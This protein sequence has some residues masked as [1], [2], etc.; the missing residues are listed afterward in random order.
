MS[1]TRA[2]TER[3]QFIELDAKGIDAIKA[4]KPQIDRELPAILE[5]FYQK[6]AAVPEVASFFTDSARIGQAKGAQLRH[7][8]QL[9]AGAFSGDYLE[10]VSRIGE[11]H[12]RIGLEPRWYVGGYALITAELVKSLLAT[13]WPKGILQ[14][15]SHEQAA[16]AIAALV[17][18]SMI[19]ME[20]AIST[21]IDAADRARKAAEEERAAAAR[22][23]AE[24]VEVLSRSLAMLAQGD[25]TVRLPDDIPQEYIQLRDDFN[26]AVVALGEAV[27]A[28][29]DAAHEVTGASLEI[30]AATN[31]FSERTEDQAASLEET[32]A[33]ME[34]IACTVRNNAQNARQ[35]NELTQGTRETA[36][37]GGVVV[38][39]AV[40]AMARIEESSRK[41]SD[42]ISVIDEIA[43]QTNLLAL[44][45][46]VEAARAGEAGRGFAVVASEVRSLAQRSSQ[47]A[48]DIKDLIVNSSS[49]VRDGV[50]LVNR[51][52]STLRE[53]VDSIK[54]VADIVS[55]IATASGE[56]AGGIEQVNKA[57]AQMDEATQQNSAMVEENAAAARMLE[58]QSNVMVERLGRF[59]VAGQSRVAAT[60]ARKAAE[61]ARVAAAPSKR[62]PATRGGAR[63]MQTALASAVK[64]DDWEEF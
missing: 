48:K 56:Q 5:G 23:Q 1:N 21:Y 35:A 3:L 43:R 17:K 7:W 41:I 60:A 16:E 28:V 39:E 42:I 2:L 44:N 54:S 53:I 10:S 11:T 58:Q 19:D 50:E 30:S 63:Q 47:A 29:A 59:K 52:G 64:A 46:A 15:Q 12:A 49:Q 22:G 36:D 33:S 13:M 57:L 55:D 6:I 51:A 45:A 4:V 24:V 32:S 27:G 9:T 40:T 62:R 34:E 61:P 31:A 8:S 25:L 38:D 26:A 20:L 14:R 18:A 37:R